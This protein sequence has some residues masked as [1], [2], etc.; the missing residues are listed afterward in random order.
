MNGERM[1][2]RQAAMIIVGVAMILSSLVTFM[3]GVNA[4]P[5]IVTTLM[6]GFIYGLCVW[7]LV[8]NDRL[9]NK[10]GES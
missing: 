9:G 10:D 5:P 2:E 1:S 6:M 7:G 3:W 8:A 4:F